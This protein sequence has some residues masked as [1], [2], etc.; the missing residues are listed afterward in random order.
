MKK[1][2]LIIGAG[3]GVS[4]ATAE[5]F[6]KE[7]F[8]IGLV[9]R[10]AANAEVMIKQLSNKGIEVYSVTADVTDHITLKQA[11]DELTQKLNGVDVLLYNAAVLKNKDILEV[12]T[13][14]FMDDF[15]VNVAAALKSVQVTLKC[16]KQSKGA[17][18]LT[19]GGFATHPSPKN[20]TLSIGKAGIRNLAMQLNERLIEEGIYVGTLTITA[21]VSPDSPIHS[22]ISLAQTYW[23]MFNSRTEVEI[24]I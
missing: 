24:V 1:S 18:L 17:I 12:D 2:I 15:K 21:K 3:A 11:I 14:E 7:G 4:L 10:N 20:G 6:G 8:A 9:N 22:P 5:K 23:E 19:G 16:L 13:A